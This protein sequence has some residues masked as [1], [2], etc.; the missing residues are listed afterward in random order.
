MVCL[1]CLIVDLKFVCKSLLWRSMLNY[2][3]LYVIERCEFAFRV[4]VVLYRYY[5][6]CIFT[7]L[8]L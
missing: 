1:C 4:V 8:F 6:M 7:R 3:I 5:I 2:L